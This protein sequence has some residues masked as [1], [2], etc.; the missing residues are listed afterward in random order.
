MKTSMTFLTLLR[1]TI[2][3][4]SACILANRAPAQQ[5]MRVVPPLAGPFYSIQRTNQP[6][7]PFNPF[8]ELEV[9]SWGEIFFF[10]DSAVDYDA[11]ESAFSSS[12]MSLMSVD[13]PPFPG[14]GG[15]GSG[16][17]NST[18]VGPAYSYGS[19]SLWLE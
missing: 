9:Y 16:S 17:G 15:G 1:A 13:P 4:L 3:A 19:N 8:P 14:G 18:N 6:P 7:L 12:S 11:I 10:D 2:V 5:L